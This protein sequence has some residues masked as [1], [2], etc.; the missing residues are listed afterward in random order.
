M[1]WRQL[2]LSK[3]RKLFR[4]LTKHGPARTLLR[5]RVAASVEHQFALA[6]L[7]CKT[8]IDV[9][10]NRGQFSL[11]ARHLFP[12]ATIIAFEPLPGPA[13]VF[14]RVFAQDINATLHELAIGPESGEHVMHVSAKED[15]SSLLPIGIAQNRIFPGTQE[16]GV[17]VVTTKR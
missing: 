12:E 14:R 3:L 11:M 1:A 15:S 17:T 7:E 6:G 9:G 5:H 10:A 4:V 8:V 13:D 16:S 2:M